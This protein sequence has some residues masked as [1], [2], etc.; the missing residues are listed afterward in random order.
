MIMSIEGFKDSKEILLCP[1]CSG[2]GRWNID[3]SEECF[4]CNG[5]GRFI[6][7]TT[8]TPFIPRSKE[9]QEEIDKIKEKYDLKLFGDVFFK[10]EFI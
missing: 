1:H 5:G 8:H 9:R 7:T 10:Y 2:T 4:Y 6:K 3:K